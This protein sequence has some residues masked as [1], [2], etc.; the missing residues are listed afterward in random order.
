[1][2]LSPFPLVYHT[3]ASNLIGRCT[4]V[5]CWR[6]RADFELRLR[7]KCTELLKRDA[8]FFLST[9]LIIRFDK[10]IILNYINFVLFHFSFFKNSKK[11][12]NIINFFEIFLLKIN[13][14]NIILLI[15][16][17]QRRSRF[18]LIF[19]LSFLIYLLKFK[20]CL[21]V[22]LSIDFLKIFNR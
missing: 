1:M 15:M 6:T 16:K 13:K 5:G 3:A 17:N 18:G 21:I 12:D 4:T 7:F 10:F 2:V 20:N 9:S 14:N 8:R 22:V 11:M 19:N